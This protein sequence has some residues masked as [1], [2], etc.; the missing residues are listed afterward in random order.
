MLLDLGL[1]DVDGADVC[2]TLRRSSDMPIIVL[3]ARGDELDRVLLLELGADDY[4]VKPFGFRELVA[5]IRAVRR[6]TGRADATERRA[7]RRA[8][9]R[10]TA[11]STTAPGASSSTTT[12]SRSRRRS[13]ISSPRLAD[14][15]GRRRAPRTAHRRGLGRALVG[16]DEDARRAHRVAAQEARRPDV[17]RD[18]PRRR[19]P[20][21]RRSAEPRDDPAARRHVSR[22]HDVRSRAA[23][24]PARHHVRAP[25]EGPAALRRR[26]RRRHDVGA[27][28]GPARDR[29]RRSRPPTSAATRDRPAAT[30]SSSTRHGIALADTEQ[31]DAAP[32][33]LR[34]GPR[35]ATRCRASTTTGTRRSDTL[36]HDA[37]L[38][39]RARSRANG[40][41]DRRGADHLRDRRRST[42]ASAASWAQLAL[43]C[44]GVLVVVAI[45]GFVLARSI[46]RPDPP[47]PGRDRPVRGRRPDGARRRRPTRARRSSGISRRRSTAWPDRLAQPPRRAAAVRRRRVASAAD[48]AH[49]AAAAAREPR[50]PR[51]RARPRRA[52]RRERRGHAHEPPRR[53]PAAA[54]ARR[55]RARS[56]RC[57]STSP[58][59]RASGSRS[60]RTSSPRRTSRSRPTLPA[61]QP[62]GRAPFPGAVEQLVDN[63][64]D[65]ALTVSPPGTRASPCGSTPTRDERRA[66]RDRRGS[67]ARRPDAASARSTGSGARPTPA[68]ADRGSGSR[69]CGSS[70][71]RPAAR[72]A[73]TPAPGGG[74]DAV[75]TLPA[76]APPRPDGTGTASSTGGMAGPA[77]SRTDRAGA[78]PPP[79]PR[80]R[81]GILACP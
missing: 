6:R 8:A 41:R 53:R 5:R 63:L 69:S 77:R 70:R 38:L 1:P 52:R 73:S 46:T 76:T 2:R 51:R 18:R 49:R 26:A 39:G 17:D 21:R 32:R 55:R 33:L 22:D 13:S 15:P 11:A 14:D 31:P 16:S 34:R 75:I 42:H 30:S 62:R 23:R 60:G 72:P 44:L 43:L 68:P 7:A 35:S 57:R 78:R 74:I 3:T 67:R 59:S 20:A 12:R 47:A 61:P 40:T 81:A 9:A 37:R 71:R 54:R 29:A 25:R 48:T 80:S 10:R 65:N 66:A 27:R 28:R 64:V 45:V 24:H 4:V 58:R 50:E 56:R 19:L 36:R 79:D